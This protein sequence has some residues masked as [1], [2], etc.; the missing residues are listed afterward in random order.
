MR[1]F[2][3][4][5]ENGRW[6][7][8]GRVDGEEGGWK[9]P[10]LAATPV[11]TELDEEDEIL[12]PWAPQFPPGGPFICKRCTETLNSRREGFERH[13]MRLNRG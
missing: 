12:L 11:G 8:S 4:F 7:R 2:R 6:V 13:R 3:I 1:D 10:L 9:P 5:R